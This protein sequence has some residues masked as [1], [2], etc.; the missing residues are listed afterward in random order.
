ML[1]PEAFAAPSVASA[2]TSALAS[3]APELATA[4]APETSGISSGLLQSFGQMGPE[5]ANILAA[6]NEG[7][8]LGGLNSTL[9]SANPTYS[10][11]SNIL[12]KGSDAL[13]NYNK[14][15]AGMNMMR[16]QQRPGPAPVGRPPS[17]NQQPMPALA[18]PIGGSPGGQ[19]MPGDED[20]ARMMILKRLGL[21]GRM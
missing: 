11:A 16:P 19:G 12:G 14:V 17:M 4:T 8:G 7:F 20:S 5:Q 1:A 10:A 3:A 21:L 15:Q 2:G 13:G 6:Q 18:P 9:Q